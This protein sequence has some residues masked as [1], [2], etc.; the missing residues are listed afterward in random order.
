MNDLSGDDIKK[1]TGKGWE[2]WVNLL[3]EV[4]ASK[5]DHKQVEQMIFDKGY[6]E[7]SW[8]CQQIATNWQSMRDKTQGQ[9]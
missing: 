5:M 8:W 1:A 9:K 4:G 6:C 3:D 2:E 7:N